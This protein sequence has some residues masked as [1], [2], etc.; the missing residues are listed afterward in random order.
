MDDCNIGIEVELSGV[1][2]VARLVGLEHLLGDGLIDSLQSVVEGL[3]GL[4]KQ[5]VAGDDLPAGLHP[6]LLEQGYEPVQ[7][8]GHAAADASGVD[9]QEVCGGNLLA[10][11]VDGLQDA[12]G[13][14]GA[15]LLQAGGGPQVLWPSRAAGQRSR[16]WALS[17]SRLSR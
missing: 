3:G 6:D 12:R 8:L 1:L 4:E 9:V 11:G 2:L 15:V 14:E 10:H 13:S 17:S 7:N 16:I 5:G